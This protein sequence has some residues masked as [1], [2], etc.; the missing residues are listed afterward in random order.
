VFD[1]SGSYILSFMPKAASN[2][3]YLR[4]FDDPA[5]QSI[6]KIT[7]A[8]APFLDAPGVYW[9]YPYIQSIYDAGITGGCST[10]PLLYCP[11]AGVTRAQM[12]V[13][14]ER[15]MH[16]AA[17]TPTDVT[18]TFGDTNGHWAEDWIEAL[19]TDGITSGCGNGNYCPDAAVTRAQMAIF[20][21]KAKHGASY[22]PPAP[23]GNIFADVPADHWAAGWIEQLAA[24]GIT[25]GCNTGVYC[26]DVSVTRAQMAVFLQHA[27][28]FSLP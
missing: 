12:A 8:G 13:F 19:K 7:N 25:S 18:P 23:S 9:A 16:G 21:L 26:P 1:P 14:L 27:F 15:G 11:E 28:G 4:M 22:V 3:L 17:F 2:I 10:S 24:E 20:L 6:W 5:N